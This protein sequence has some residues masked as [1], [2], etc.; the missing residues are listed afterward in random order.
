[1]T[2]LATVKAELTISGTTHDAYFAALIQQASSKAVELSGRE[3]AQEE[4][5]DRF[6][7]ERCDTTLRL[8]RRPIASVTSLEEGGTALTAGT[9]FEILAQAGQ[10]LRIDGDGTPRPWGYGLVEI[11][12]VAG[13]EML[14]EL[15]HALERIVIDEVKRGW[16]AR[17]RDPLLKAEDVPGVLRSEWWIDRGSGGKDPMLTALADAG[18]VDAFFV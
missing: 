8:T 15:P 11:V 17:E 6:R 1:M 14:T 9:D 12:Y 3:F 7:V 13:W 5:T 10:L 4:L 2:T 18:F 16:M